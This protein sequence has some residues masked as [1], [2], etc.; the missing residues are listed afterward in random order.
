VELISF[1]VRIPPNRLFG[2]IFMSENSEN[3]DLFSMAEKWPSSYVARKKISELTGGI[4]S[5]KYLANLDCAGK[6]PSKRIRIGGQ[7]AY[8][9]H[10][11]IEWLS[12]RSKTVR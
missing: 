9:I 1:S 5:P 3:I 10:A 12:S 6:G 8:E 11:L 2:G 4:I 7:I